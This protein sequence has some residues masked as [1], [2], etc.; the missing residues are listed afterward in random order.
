MLI[1]ST[2]QLLLPGAKVDQHVPL[3]PFDSASRSTSV[4]RGVIIVE[5][6][7]V[8]RFTEI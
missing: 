7:D 5:R 1:K 2:G 3:N 8:V 6:T 4:D